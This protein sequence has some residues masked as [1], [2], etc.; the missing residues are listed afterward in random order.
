M[1]K[2]VRSIRAHIFG[3][4]LSLGLCLTLEKTPPIW[5]LMHENLRVRVW[6]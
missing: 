4:S 2:L 5:G 6:G 1:G 3:L